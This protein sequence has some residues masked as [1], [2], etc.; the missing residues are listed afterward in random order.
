MSY[1]LNLNWQDFLDN[2]WQKK[3]VLIKHAFNQF[4]DPITPEILA[5]LAMEQEI[6]SRIVTNHNQQWSLMHG[7]FENFSELTDSHSTL[8]VQAVNHWYEEVNPLLEPFRCLPNWRLDD[9]MISYSTPNGGVGPHVDQ[10]DVFILQGMGKRHWRVGEIQNVKSISPHPQLLQIEGFETYIDVILEP[11][12]LLYIPPLAPHEGY[13]IEP[14]LNYSIGF[15]A[16]NARELLSGFADYVIENQ[17]GGERYYDKK[18]YQLPSTMLRDDVHSINPTELIALKSMLQNLLEDDNHFTHFAGSFLSQSRHELNLVEDECVTLEELLEIVH[19]G[20]SL[21]KLSGLRI[22]HLDNHLFI[23]G[24]MFDIQ[25]PIL[26]NHILKNIPFDY[27]TLSSI[28][29][30]ESAMN[31]LLELVNHGYW[32]FDSID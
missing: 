12:D 26:K 8:L 15:R 14:S 5:G 2:Y 25:N 19:E 31:Q 21:I 18:A 4:I 22:I 6:D 7:P 16:P 32:H 1:I 30:D 10:Y 13:A 17:L 20:E 29:A 23:N 3:P 27:S 9:L 24:E 28:Q 11:G